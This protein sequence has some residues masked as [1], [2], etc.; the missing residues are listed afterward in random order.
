MLYEVIT[1]EQAGKQ[2][3]RRFTAGRERV[4]VRRPGEWCVAV[5]GHSQ[6]LDAALLARNNFV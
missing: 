3:D 6:G 2:S 4:A 5:T 1:R